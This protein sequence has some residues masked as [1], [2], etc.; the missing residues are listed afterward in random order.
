MK[1]PKPKCTKDI[2]CNLGLTGYIWKFIKYYSA[3][4][5]T[6]INILRKD[7]TFQFSAVES[8]TLRNSKTFCHQNQHPKSTT[9]MNIDVYGA[10][11]IDR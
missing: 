6:F 2:N 10:V 4:A 7:S 5:K 1:I 3:I 8:K 11:L 9:E